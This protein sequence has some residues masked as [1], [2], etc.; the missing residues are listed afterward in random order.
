VR[1]RRGDRAGA[2]AD[3]NEAIRLDPALEPLL[4]PRIQAAR[5]ARP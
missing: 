3:W 4:R 2:I 5:E 1:E